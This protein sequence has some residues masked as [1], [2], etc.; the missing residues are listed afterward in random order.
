MIE[1]KEFANGGLNQDVDENFLKPNEGDYGL[2]I[3]NTDRVE[4]SDGVI[5]NL[6]GTTEIGFSE[7]FNNVFS[8]EFR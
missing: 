1:K 5:S 8:L 4:F 7:I 3:R 2:N 6:K